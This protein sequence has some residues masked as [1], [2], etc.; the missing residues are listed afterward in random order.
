[1]KSLITLLFKYYVFKFNIEYN[2]NIDLIYMKELTFV[3]EPLCILLLN[4]LIFLSAK[5]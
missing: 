4:R 3:Y 1:M 5:N 2:P